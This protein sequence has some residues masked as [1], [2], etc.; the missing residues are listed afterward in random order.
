MVFFCV[1]VGIAGA[2]EC[3]FLHAYASDECY[4]LYL[5]IFL[6]TNAWNRN[7]MIDFDGLSLSGI[8]GP[9]AFCDTETISL[10]LALI[11]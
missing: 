9:D 2:V 7:L 6:E 11:M 1:F 4:Q 10:I 5:I 3:E 8:L